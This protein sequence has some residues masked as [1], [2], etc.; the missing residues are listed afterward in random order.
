MSPIQTPQLPQWASR[1][2]TWLL[3][4]LFPK[5]CPFCQRILED[6]RAP[7]CPDCQKTL[8]WLSGREAERP[9]EFTSGCLSPLA[10]RGRVPDSVHRYKFPGTP[11]YAGAYGLLIAQCVRDNRAAPLDLVTWVPLSPKR[12]R[13]RGFDQA[14]AL[15]RAA[16]QELGLPVRGTLEKFRNNGP[17][18]HLHEASERR[19][20]VLGAYRLREG[21]EPAGLRILLVDDVV[22]SGAT[23]SECARLLR[24]AGAAEVLCATLAQARKS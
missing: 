4:L 12:K 11:S 16:A 1:A 21:A 19:A 2:G 10:Y 17:Q 8:P 15:A 13:K 22:T 7:A 14:E 18:S 5:K 9:E 24:S 6:P 23:L 20:N 3:D